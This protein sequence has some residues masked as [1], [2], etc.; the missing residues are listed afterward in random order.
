MSDMQLGML[1]QQQAW[2][3]NDTRTAAINAA[4]Q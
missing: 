1:N 3:G 4:V 2:G